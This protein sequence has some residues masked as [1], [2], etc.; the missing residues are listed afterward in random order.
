MTSKISWAAA[1]ATVRVALGVGITLGL[2]QGTVAQTFPAKPIELIVP[3]PAGSSTDIVTRLISEPLAAKL[4]VSLVPLNAA[5]ADGIVGTER[6]AR[7]AP[8]GYTLGVVN[9]THPSLPFLY[10]NFKLDPVKDFTPI[11]MFGR[12]A[13]LA[14]VN[15]SFPAKNAKEFVALVRANPG[16][17]NYAVHSGQIELDFGSMAKLADLKM[18]PISY[19]GGAQAGVALLS[20]EVHLY[21]TGI[22]SAI[23]FL[24]SGQMRAIAV[25]SGERFPGLDITET[26]PLLSEEIPGYRGSSAW[27][28]LIGPA[29]MPEAVVK[30][31]GDACHEAVNSEKVLAR[32]KDLYL[33]P[34][35]GGS[36]EMRDRII[37]DVDNTRKQ[38]Q[39][40]GV[41]PR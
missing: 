35:R 7:S 33:L 16:K 22:V 26:L 34:A 19:R 28:G 9:S 10:S 23:P 40:T 15:A 32:F 12:S 13:I 6:I 11:C 3:T 24:K 1:R 41:K 20:N 25:S 2:A 38:V 36:A 29:G 30:K 17:Y 31:I 39:Q 37:A 4:G 18:V 27:F 21:A 8:D 14:L 5:G